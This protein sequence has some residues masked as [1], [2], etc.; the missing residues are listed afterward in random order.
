MNTRHIPVLLHETAALLNCREG[1]TY[2]DATVGSGGH[3]LHLLQQHPGIKMLI[4]IDRDEEAIGRAQKKLEPFSHKAAVLHGNFKELKTILNRAGIDKADGILFDLG[5]SSPQLDDP[6][7]GF[8]FSAE[9][10]LDMRMDRNTPMDAKELLEQLS[11][12]D[13]EDILRSFGEERWARRIA[14]RI[15][16]QQQQTPIETTTQLRDIVYRAIPARHA[17]KIHPATKTF[18]ALRIAVNDELAAVASGLDDA[19]EL[20]APQGRLCAISFHSLED[21]IVK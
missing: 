8:S 15:K 1:G 12:R 17:G 16:E 21:R 14:R 4:G 10:P 2:V 7:R 20:L 18:Q 13:I 6:A 5:V 9:G 19:I 3:A 11:A